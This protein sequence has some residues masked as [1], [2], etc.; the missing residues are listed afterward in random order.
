MCHQIHKVVSCDIVINQQI[1]KVVNCDV[2]INEQIHKVVNCDFVIY[3]QIQKVVNCEFDT[4]TSS[5]CVI[6]TNPQHNVCDVNQF[7]T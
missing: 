2:V 1:H 3:Q 4:K 7:S 5:Y 6:V